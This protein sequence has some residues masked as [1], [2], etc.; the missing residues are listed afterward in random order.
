[1]SNEQPITEPKESV[2][3]RLE[4]G[5]FGPHNIANPKGRPPN[6]YS[7]TDAIHKAIDKTPSIKNKLGK[8]I[9]DKALAGDLKAIEVIWAYMDGKPT[10]RVDAKIE[11]E[12]K[13]IDLIA[14]LLQNAYEADDKESNKTASS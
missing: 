7:I 5:T 14:A 10:Q 13:A 9:I 11:S 3:N 8:K 12:S 4:N 1:M 6:T 2:D